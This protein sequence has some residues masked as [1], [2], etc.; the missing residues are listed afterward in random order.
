MPRVA[1]AKLNLA[2]AV[3]PPLPAGDPNRGMPPI[4]SWMH[5][6][7]LA[8]EV[9][10]RPLPSRPSRMEIWWATKQSVF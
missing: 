9:E 5:A 4:A 3:G 1:Y 7:D 2:L 10:V 6:I 8:D